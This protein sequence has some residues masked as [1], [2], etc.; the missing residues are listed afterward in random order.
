M[1]RATPP[2]AVGLSPSVVHQLREA[3]GDKF[4]LT[5]PDELLV[6]EADALT[7]HKHIPVAVVI[8]GTAEEVAACVRILAAE[9]I[10]FTPRGAG[11]GLSGGALSLHGAVIFELATGRLPFGGRRL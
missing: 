6:Y 5:D 9:K 10:P 2:S 8:P 11:T 4:V 3:I 1:K 7:I